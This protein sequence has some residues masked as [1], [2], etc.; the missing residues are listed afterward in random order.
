MKR[1]SRGILVLLATVLLYAVFTP[2][3]AYARPKTVDLSK[4]ILQNYNKI[5]YLQIG[6]M[7]FQGRLIDNS[8]SDVVIDKLIDEV[9]NEMELTAEEFDELNTQQQTPLTDQEKRRGWKT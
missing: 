7:T 2:A 4:T 3:S 5:V 9:L 8:R 1:L 6:D